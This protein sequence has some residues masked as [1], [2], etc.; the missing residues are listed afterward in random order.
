MKLIDKYL[1]K[2]LLIPLA[3]CLGGFAMV[4]VISELFGDVNRILDANPPWYIIMR[5][6][7]AI[8]GP[9]LQFLAP[10]SLMLATLYTLFGLTRNSELIAMRAS[11]V[12]I[13][14]IMM[15]FLW[16]G[17]AMTAATA[18]LNEFWVPHTFEWAENIRSNRFLITDTET[19]E[20]CIYLNP[21]AH[22][23]WII[24]EMDP[25][26]PGMLMDVEV[27]QERP[28]GRRLF[29]ITA[30]RAEYLDGQWWFFGP[31]IQRFGDS[32][33]PIGTRT[34]I[35]DG[36]DS[37]VEMREFDELPT[38]FIS[39]VRKW[40]YLNARE[41]YHYIKTHPHMSPRSWSEK[42]FSLHSRLAMPWACLIVV[43]FAIPAGARTGRQGVMSA[44]FAAVTLMAGFY[45]LAQIG[46]VLGS[47]GTTPPWM[48]AWLSN[49]V[50]GAVGL[51]LLARLR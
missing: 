9:A 18:A 7:L 19:V 22:R 42:N 46:L 37:V 40:D 12:S 26:H 43:L 36:L 45:A 5:Y 27:K 4:L 3:Y 16:V 21:N 33:N 11:G 41:M 50:F 13:Y 34:F 25:R 24:G 47:T 6:Y 2:E 32:D 8:L 38:A 17:I 10:S 28:D 48:A 14:R 1:L 35:G 30:P 39:A 23:Q 31:S 20:Q 51:V 15:P 29:I 49:T 44:V